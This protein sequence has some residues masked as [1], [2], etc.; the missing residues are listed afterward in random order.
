LLSAVQSDDA[1]SVVVT[2][3]VFTNTAGMGVRVA[4]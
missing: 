4:L 2:F 3:S 1:A